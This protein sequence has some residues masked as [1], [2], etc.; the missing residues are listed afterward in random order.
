MS[1]F[2]VYLGE[3]GQQFV[4]AVEGSAFVRRAKAAPQ[5]F[6]GP[7]EIAEGPQYVGLGVV[8]DVFQRPVDLS[9]ARC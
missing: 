7:G 2:R 3:R 1:R 5:Q 8:Q 4:G 9:R 6:L